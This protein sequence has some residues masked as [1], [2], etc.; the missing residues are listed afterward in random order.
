MILENKRIIRYLQCKQQAVNDI[1]EH[2][3]N[4]T[5]EEF[6][7]NKAKRQATQ[8]N[9]IL[10][11]ENAGKILAHEGV[12]D[13]AEEIF[14]LAKGMRNFIAHQYEDVNLI[15]VYATV[16]ADIPGLKH[17]L[18]DLIEEAIEKDSL[19]DGYEDNYEGDGMGM[20]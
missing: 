13:K 17:V 4:L 16:K 2:T 20:H 12:S 7:D 10:L 6:V 5:F 18:S 14:N 15:S 9:F 8:L 1:L 11:G 19:L 3:N